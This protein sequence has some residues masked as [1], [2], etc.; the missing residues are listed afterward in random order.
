MDVVKSLPRES[1]GTRCVERTLTLLRELSSRGEFG[2]RLSDLSQQVG[3]DQATCHRMLGALVKEGFAARYAGDL[4]YYPG[5]ALFELGLAVPSMARFRELVEPRLE[6]LATITGCIASFSL[7]SGNDVVCVFQE[8]AGIDLPSMLI[9]VGSR[10][11][12]AAAVAGLAI[13]QLLAFERAQEI[14]AENRLREARRGPERL[15][16]LDTM[17]QR[18]LEKGF[19]WTVGD[20]APGLAALGLPV[21]DAAGQPFAALT[22]TGADGVLN[23]ATL[24][25]IREQALAAVS[26]LEADAV[27]CLRGAR[28][29]TGGAGCGWPA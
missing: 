5:V 18:S 19:G 29:E 15:R 28:R 7:R 1:P 9:R 25:R 4:K 13:L 6:L 11:S 21:R 14:L 23:E 26:L 27:R 16:Q 2:W 12:M 10:R 20:L 8:R 22:L 3:I 17:W 24:P